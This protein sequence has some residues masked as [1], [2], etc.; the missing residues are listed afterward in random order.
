M[1]AKIFSSVRT[2]PT[3]FL[4][5]ISCFSNDFNAYRGPTPPPN[6]TKSTIPTSP[7]PSCRNRWNCRSLN[8]PSRFTV[9]SSA[10]AAGSPA[11]CGF[12][13]ASPDMKFAQGSTP[14]Q[15]TVRIAAPTTL[16]AFMPTGAACSTD[17]CAVTSTCTPTKKRGL[18]V[19]SRMGAT[20][21]M[22][23]NGAPSLR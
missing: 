15:S 12:G 13:R 6:A 20:V 3:L 22:F 9:S 8:F 19:T 5:T 4:S 11:W 17:G 10:A 23:Q 7:E 1:V 21:S 14:T 2:R 16:A 18:P